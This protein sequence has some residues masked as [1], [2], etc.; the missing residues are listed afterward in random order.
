[1]R[2]IDRRRK[3]M[4]RRLAVYLAGPEVFLPDTVAVGERK[5]Q[6]CARYGFEG[7]Y[8]LDNMLAS[9]PGGPPLDTQ[10]Y[11]ANVALIR[12]ADFGILNLTPFCGPTADSGTVFELG[13]LVGLGKRVFAYTNDAADLIERVRR[14]SV[15]T[16]DAPAKAWRDTAG[17]Q[18]E[19]FGKADNVM[20]DAALA[21]QGCPIVRH[22]AR[23]DQ[24]FRDLT[25]FETCL[26]L[27]AAALSEGSGTGRA[28]S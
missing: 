11:R 8:P 15:L 3:A 9:D 6:L 23:S 28:R 21:D 24:L 10:I 5:K 22:A 17:M 18:I 1:M 26:Q 27:A 14:I 13:M 7:L 16:Y 25:G 19:D 2:T 12:Q 4:R 20:I